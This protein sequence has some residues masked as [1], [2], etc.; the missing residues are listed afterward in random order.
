MR[1]QI[2]TW[3][4]L[5]CVA[6]TFT[7]CLGDDNNHTDESSECAII[8][9]SVGD[10]KSY[11][12][13]TNIYGRDT[14]VLRTVSG[15]SIYFNI[16]HINNEITTVDSLAPWIDLRKV[17][18][19]VTAY[20]TVYYQTHPDSTL[21]Y[22][23]TDS[24]DFTNPLYF[25]VVAND[26]LSSRT[27]KVSMKLA[28]NEADSLVWTPVASDLQQEG[29][30]RSIFFDDRLFVFSYHQGHP[31]VTS[32]SLLSGLQSW[33]VPHDITGTDGEFDYS[34]VISFNGALYALDSNGQL[35][36]SVSEPTNRAEVWTKVGG[37][38]LSRLLAA[39]SH[40]L[41]ALRGDAI[42][43]SSDLSSWKEFGVS[44]TDYLPQTSISS[45]A[46]TSK[47]NGALENVVMTGLSS[48][49][50]DYGVTWYKV[51]SDDDVFNQQWSYVEVTADNPY[52][53]P[54]LDN[55]QMVRYGDMLL[56][57]GG[58]DLNDTG[59]LSYTHFY[60]SDDNGITWH[61]QE[62]LVMP[63]AAVRQ[64]DKP[65]SLAVNGNYIYLLQGGGALWRGIIDSH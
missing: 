1:N 8:S 4:F 58:V 55:L 45:V 32:S 48:Q 36:T 9:F 60:R 24:I 19:S 61:K 59:S 23:G 16:D 51:S 34:S 62:S 11:V 57:T 17:V 28:S 14:L 53:C 38:S 42:V 33:R 52:G 50:R 63:P 21:H 29:L 12:T 22:L 46:Y 44:A 54:K 26:G 37:G 3:F 20:G 40:Y 2:H 35:Y 30:M 43:G 6:F 47:V 39:D 13:V 5:L 18:P 25:K 10:I 65:V 31:Q 7:A 49:V 56:L 27:Y 41:Y 15:K 64:V